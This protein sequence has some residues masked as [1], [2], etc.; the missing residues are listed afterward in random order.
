MYFL[1]LNLSMKDFYKYLTSGE[2]DRNWG[3]YLNV[4]G[5]YSAKPG[6]PYPP[7]K[8]P[9]GYYFNWMNGRVLQE[10]QILYVTEGGGQLETDHGKFTLKLGSVF[11]IRPGIWHR[12]KPNLKSGWKE[13]Y[14]GFNGQMAAQFLDHPL[15]S[16]SQPVLN[17]GVHVEL[18]D[19]YEKIFD[20]VN[21]EQPGFQQIASGLIVKLLG[22]LISFEKQRE[23]QGKRIASI[24]EDARFKMRQNVEK[25]L[26]MEKMAMEYHIG[27]SYF[28]K[29][30]K[31]YTGVA[32]HKYHL[33]LKIIRAKE[34]LL[35]S[36]KSV[37]EISYDL[38]FQSI[39][40]F[41]RL[42]KNKVGK[43]PTEFRG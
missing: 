11:I 27:Y 40:Y 14:I 42:F 19:T 41:S 38:G 8:H 28:R 5:S 9:S 1:I 33:E 31:S 4:A 20:L 21:E 3:F 2:E 39:H 23:F 24:I 26:D 34:L 43:S 7:V 12:Y 22:Y 37:K 6:Q 17:P 15:F 35:A 30:F 32:P 29:M 10:F 16:E 18:I 25:E 13:H 36:N